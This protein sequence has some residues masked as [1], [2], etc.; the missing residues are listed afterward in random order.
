M[1]LRNRNTIEHEIEGL[2]SHGDEVAKRPAMQEQSRH[3]QRIPILAE[4]SG[5]MAGFVRAIQ[6]TAKQIHPTSDT[7]KSQSI[8]K[9]PL[10]P[11]QAGLSGRND[12][13]ARQHHSENPPAC[14]RGKKEN[15]TK[16]PGGVEEN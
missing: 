15:A 1:H 16:K 12:V 7:D 11:D 9:Y 2:V 4:Y 5:S 6:A 10:S 14:Q 8:G 13:D 3:A